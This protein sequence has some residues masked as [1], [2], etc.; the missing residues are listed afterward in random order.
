MLEQNIL[1]GVKVNFFL[2]SNYHSTKKRQ[3]KKGIKRG[4]WTTNP[5]PNQVHFMSHRGNTMSNIVLLSPNKNK[6]NATPSSNI[7]NILNNKRER[8]LLNLID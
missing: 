4:W 5:I 7:P 3:Q 2:T 8:I 1:Q 6:R